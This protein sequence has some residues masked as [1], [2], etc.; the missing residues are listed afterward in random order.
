MTVARPCRG[1]S[2]QCNPLNRLSDMLS[3]KGRLDACGGSL[4]GMFEAFLPGCSPSICRL[5]AD[6]VALCQDTG[7]RGVLIL[8]PAGSGKSTLARAIALGRYLYS[9]TQ[10]MRINVIKNLQVDPPAR[11]SKRHLNYYE[12]MSL[13]GL[14][15]SLAESQLF[16]VIEGAATTVT[17][18]PGIFYQAMMGHQS[19]KLRIPA[20]ALMT[21]GVVF[22]DEI[23]DLPSTLQPKLLTILT[24]SEVSPVGAEGDE[25]KAYRFEG[26]TIA[27]T[28][29]EPVGSG[30]RHD[31]LSRL[32]DHVLFVPPLTRRLEDFDIVVDS[33]MSELKNHSVEWLNLRKNLKGFDKDRLSD[34]MSSVSDSLLSTD[35][36]IALRQVNWNEHADLRGLAQTIRRI[37]EQGLSAEEAISKQFRLSVGTDSGKDEASGLVAT[38][39]AAA[40]ER[41]YSDFSTLFKSLEAENRETLLSALRRNP[42]AMQELAS[43]FG[44]TVSVIKR[45]VNNLSRSR[46]STVAS[47][48]DDGL[49]DL[50]P[51]EG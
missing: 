17:A 28:W 5:R 51:T 44:T 19:D 26:L 13:T 45:S 21:G 12:E 24:G 10:E 38:L 50:S 41:H 4:E 35:D 37:R 49:D 16:G 3:T 48:A 1:L 23:G 18:R 15:A 25:S 30:I 40:A 6:S 34:R 7:A 11:I 22:L 31:L 20:A 32:T 36:R 39:L 27:A 9:L 8:G 42:L 29:K 2:H 47:T 46:R 43:S 14:V 33:I